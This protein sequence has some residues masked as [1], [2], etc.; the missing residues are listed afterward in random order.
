MRLNKTVYGSGT[1]KLK[2]SWHLVQVSVG[3]NAGL[4]VKDMSTDS[5]VAQQ[6]C[7]KNNS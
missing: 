2:I 6:I 5:L 4:T 3:I 7:S 1:T